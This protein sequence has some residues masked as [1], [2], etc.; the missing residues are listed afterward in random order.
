MKVVVAEDTV[1]IADMLCMALEY[2]DVEVVKVTSDFTSLLTPKPWQGVDAVVCDLMLP[3]MDGEDIIRYVAE[4]HPGIARVV[5]SAV[6]HQRE[7]LDELA[8]CI[9]KPVDPRLLL[10]AL[11]VRRDA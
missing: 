8:T 7:G 6:A 4:H 9:S 10:N 5:L 11:G 3:G 2:A 1:A